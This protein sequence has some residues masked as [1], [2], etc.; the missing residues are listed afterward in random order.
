[1]GKR[2][3]AVINT[4]NEEK[5][6]ERAIKSVMWADEILVCDMYSIDST[7]EIAKKMGAKVILHKKEGYVEPARN[8]AISKAKNEWILIL[9]ADEEIPGSLS[10]E[11]KKM[12]NKP[13][14][15]DFIELPRKNIIFNKW[16]KA[17]GWWPDYH[18]RVFKQGKVLWSSKIH[19]KPET[20][21]QG[22]TLPPEEKWAIVHYNYR[23]LSQFIHRMDRYTQI[24]AEELRKS[25]Y[26]FKWQDVFQKPASEFLSRYF[27]NKGYKDG[28]HGLALSLLQTFSFLVLY[29]KVWEMSG[30]K[31]QNLGVMEFETEAKII[32][33]D[34]N[35][36]LDQS[37]NANPF[38]NFLKI[39]KK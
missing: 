16:I 25:G 38:N 32:G 27:S 18:V 22:V 28:L 10:V 26:Q 23:S 29:L 31:E 17:T 37:K 35:Y 20:K 36:W 9:D 2:I 15:S 34:V 7:R 11:I 4:F 13:M 1:M 5:N 39:F 24:Q 12:I 8:F 30:F 14:V 33:K 6:I 19:E 3:S 21:G